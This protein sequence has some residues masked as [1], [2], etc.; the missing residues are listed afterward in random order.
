MVAILAGCGDSAPKVDKAAIEKSVRAVEAAMGKAA[1]ARDAGAFAANYTADAIM[2]VPSQP[3]MKTRDA[4]KNGLGELFKDPALKLDA[5][6]DRIEI[7]ENGDMAASRG[8]FTMTLTGPNKEVIHDH[9]SYVTVFRKQAD[10]SW[11]AVM[12]INNSEV[13]PAAPAPPAPKP[14]PKVV[15]K[16]RRR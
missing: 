7:S 15:K 4:I 2:M 6:S 1:D 14:E 16:G 9:G 12:D 10:G 3:A 11:R 13:A 5:S 8:I